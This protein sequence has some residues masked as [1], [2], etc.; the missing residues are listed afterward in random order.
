MI[1]NKET[2][3]MVI[4]AEECAEVAIEC[5]KI[6]RFGAKEDNLDR[7]E[8]EFGDLMC[9]YQMLVDEGYLHPSHVQSYAN[10]KKLKLRK[11][12]GLVE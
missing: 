1:E 5:S 9:M 12:S 3:L 7:L 4:T 6:I 11:Y 8:K 10:E 2:E